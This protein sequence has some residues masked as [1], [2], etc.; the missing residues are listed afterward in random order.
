M[1][2]PPTHRYQGVEAISATSRGWRRASS[3][4]RHCGL[5]VLW[6]ANPVF[7]QP[8]PE[9]VVQV[10]SE[11]GRERF[12]DGELVVAASVGLALGP[13]EEGGGRVLTV[14]TFGEVVTVG[15]EEHLDFGI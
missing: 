14:K 9:P 13:Q 15:D 8:G 10:L 11:A 2:R 6:A 1:T 3:P 5:R 7:I 12:L 4:G